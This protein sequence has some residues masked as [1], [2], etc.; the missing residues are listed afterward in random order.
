MS[1]PQQRQIQA[2]SATYTTA[3]GNAR[4]LTHWARP[5]IEPK[6]SLFL[7]G[8]ISSAPWWELLFLFLIVVKHDSESTI[9]T[10]LK[11]TAPTLIH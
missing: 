8:F 4:S 6:T 1:Q 10:I 3:H 9:L 5:G 11:Y 7:V 2:K